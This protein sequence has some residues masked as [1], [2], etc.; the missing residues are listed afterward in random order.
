[1]PPEL[2]AIPGLPSE[3][4]QQRIAAAALT[5]SCSKREAAPAAVAAT[6]HTLRW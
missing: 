5:I 4:R 1:L 3:Q 6:Q 2:P